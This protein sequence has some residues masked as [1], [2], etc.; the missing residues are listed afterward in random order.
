MVHDNNLTGRAVKVLALSQQEARQLNHAYVGTEH[1]LLALLRE[2]H[3]LAATVL[4]EQGVEYK[5]MQQAISQHLYAAH[6]H[7]QRKYGLYAAVATLAG[8][9]LLTYI[10]TH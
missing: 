6:R 10:F 8:I 4:K 3:G 1:L 7:Q 5:D 9:A 2:G